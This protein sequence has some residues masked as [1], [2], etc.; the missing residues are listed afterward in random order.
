MSQPSKSAL[1][2]LIEE[3]EQCRATDK[4]SNPEALKEMLL[5]LHAP[6]SLC[7]CVQIACNLKRIFGYVLRKD[8]CEEQHRKRFF[9]YLRELRWIT[10]NRS[11]LAQ[12]LFIDDGDR[13]RFLRTERTNPLLRHGAREHGLWCLL[14]EV[15]SARESQYAFLTLQLHATLSHLAVLGYWITQEEWLQ[16][17]DR[18]NGIVNALYRETLSIRHFVMEKYKDADEHI[19]VLKGI[20]TGVSN[21]DLYGYIRD[22][23]AK[24]KPSE[25]SKP[26]TIY[27]DMVRISWLLH[28]ASH[29]GKFRFRDRNS[30]LMPHEVPDDSDAEENGQYGDPY[31]VEGFELEDSLDGD[32]DDRA[33]DVNSNGEEEEEGEG[34]DSPEESSI[35]VTTRRKWSKD[36]I[37]ACVES[38]LHPAEV[39][40]SHTM[41]LS[42]S[43]SGHVGAR[44][45][46]EMDNQLLPWSRDNMPVEIA[47]RGMK[48]LQHAAGSGCLMDLELY[49]H[50]LVI[51]RTGAPEKT[52]QSMQVRRDLKH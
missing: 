11:R 46:V 37:K 12:D 28:H 42:H 38:G 19:A 49:I 50:A 8:I 47:A 21:A 36:Q 30:L 43:K 5:H 14:W 52:V 39:L 18:A 1:D 48:A 29:P 23:S 35:F 24:L 20:P 41:Y 10:H 27:L 3:R 17:T 45:W 22:T 44:A 31:E 13:E 51:L 26:S 2:M 32:E 33:A 16:S 25:D 9:L 40:P 6:E 4:S 15:H 34:E 7:G